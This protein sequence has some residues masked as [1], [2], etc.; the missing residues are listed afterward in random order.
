M[1]KRAPSKKYTFTLKNLNIQHINDKYDIQIP[2]EEESILSEK[3]IDNTTKLTELNNNNK[4]TPELISF[5]DESKRAHTCHISMIDFES[6]MDVNLLRYNCY[7]CR[8]PFETRP[9]GCPI[10]YVSSQAEKRYNSHIS[11]DVYTIKENVT[12]KKRE[13]MD[14]NTN[15]QLSVKRAEYYVTDG[16]FCSFNC[17]QAWINDNKHTYKYKLSSV[18]LMKMYNSFMNTKMVVIVPAPHWRILEQYGGHLNIIKFREGFNKIGYTYH[19]VTKNL[20][21][22]LPEGTLFEEN[23]KF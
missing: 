8:H 14:T 18:L 22:F 10:K 15:E 6:R 19:G 7:W 2:S 20:P 9:I 5:L 16:V 1:S 23:I 21:K 3:P 11:R 4:G 17:C 12:S 13:H